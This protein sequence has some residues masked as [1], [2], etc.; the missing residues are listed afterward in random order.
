M[1]LRSKVFLRSK[2]C[3]GAKC[4]SA[5]PSCFKTLILCGV[6]QWQT[7]ELICINN[8]HTEI[9]E[10]CVNLHHSLI[11]YPDFLFIV[12]HNI[13]HSCPFKQTKF[14]I[15]RSKFIWVIC[16][17]LKFSLLLQSLTCTQNLKSLSSLLNLLYPF[18]L[19]GHYAQV[20]KWS[21]L[22]K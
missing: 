19:W 12:I 16:F 7:L 18:Q 21:I 14:T 1:L 6:I 17:A 4:S 5:F 9:L 13:Q 15:H 2:M 20:L 11:L 3:F 22:R 8:S 10:K